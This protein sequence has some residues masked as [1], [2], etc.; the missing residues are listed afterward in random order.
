MPTGM[1]LDETAKATW[2]Y[3]KDLGRDPLFGRHPKFQQPEVPKGQVNVSF[4]TYPC[5]PN[6]GLGNID[7]VALDRYFR[8]LADNGVDIAPIAVHSLG[9]KNESSFWDVKFHIGRNAN[10]STSHLNFFTHNEADNMFHVIYNG[11]HITLVPAY[12]FPVTVPGVDGTID[13]LSFMPNN[14]FEGK[15]PLGYQ[16]RFQEFKGANDRTDGLLIAPHPYTVNAGRVIKFRPAYGRERHQI[17]SQVFPNIDA[18]AVVST[19]AAYMT[20]ANEVVEEDFAAD[21]SPAIAIAN[22]NAHVTG[23]M[24]AREV[25]RAGNLMD[26]KFK[27]YNNS[28][29][30]LRAELEEKLKTGD[31]KPYL[32]YT[33]ILPFL[34]TVAL[35]RTV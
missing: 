20:A 2:T 26:L 17:R 15:I 27:A 10:G 18:A 7:E 22:D 1:T 12:E 8:A 34:A 14:E 4:H 24:G 19:N 21:R 33:P 5:I 23:M 3:L 29:P 30:E 9:S 6:D 16:F 25:G 28:G 11:K 31:V 35:N 13:M 32:H